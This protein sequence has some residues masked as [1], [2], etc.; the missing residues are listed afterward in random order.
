M[1][2]TQHLC[3]N[4][5]WLEEGSMA[6]FALE[7]NWYTHLKLCTM[8]T[9]FPE[10]GFQF[11]LVIRTVKIWISKHVNIHMLRYPDL[12]ASIS[13][14]LCFKLCIF[15]RILKHMHTWF[16]I[17]ISSI[18]ILKHHTDLKKVAWHVLHWNKTDAHT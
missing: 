8:V 3:I 1:Q 11:K 13:G 14:F 9:R 2:H 15:V 4:Q 10:S 5:N 12:Y 18:Q 16:D 17:R 7:Q 6:C